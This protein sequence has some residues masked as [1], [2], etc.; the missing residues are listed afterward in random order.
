MF[1]RRPGFT[2][3]ALSTIALGIGA[4]VTIFSIVDRTLLR[5]LPFPH[6]E[7]LVRVFE[8][9]DQPISAPSY[10]DMRDGTRTAFSALAAWSY[11]TDD[12]LGTVVGVLPYGIALPGAD[13]WRPL[14]FTPQQLANRQSAF[15]QSA[16]RL[17]EGVSLDQAATAL[18]AAMTG[19]YAS[20][21]D[22]DRRHAGVGRPGS[23]RSTCCAPSRRRTTIRSARRSIDQAPGPSI[24][25][26]EAVS[27][28][29]RCVGAIS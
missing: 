2:A 11:P 17:R 3:V 22:A 16:G 1:A 18:G 8:N 9:G 13:I 4:N 21:H 5:R 7:R 12:A 15:L 14:V 10:Q 26:L 27:A 29:I 28:S 20:A 6:L 23:I 19:V 25:R 24:T